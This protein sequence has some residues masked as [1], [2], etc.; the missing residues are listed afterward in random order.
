MEEK[1]YLHKLLNMFNPRISLIIGLISI[2]IFPVLVKWAAVS[3]ITSAFYR[4]FIGFVCLLPYV[5]ITK[6][7][8]VPPKSLW[9]SVIICG[10]LFG[11]D[12]AVWN[13]SIHY[14]NATQAT[15]LTNLAPIWVGIGSFFFLANKPKKQ[16]WLGTAVAISGLAVL[17]GAE[18]FSQM[19]FDKGFILALI[20]GILY[21]TYMIV[22]QTVLTHLKIVSFMTLSMGVSSIYLLIIC[23]VL[24]EP[25]WYFSNTVWG[26]MAIQGIICQLIGW[27][28]LSYAVQKMDAQRVSL[29]LLSQGVITG[30][31][32]WLFI[33]EQIS[34]RMVIGGIIILAGI[35]I[36]FR[37][38]ATN[39]VE[40]RSAT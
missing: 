20:S 25:L 32:A 21:A 18:T 11:T 34:L 26:V 13:V 35:G 30:V 37:Q 7:L 1:L 27:L 19:Q 16:F 33:D 6:Q 39:Q 31:M 22:S 14:S 2:S 24:G 4:L 29:S 28:A 23:L 8:T 9:V 40:S 36:T 15:L 17:L 5:L 38:S 12:I 3:G 10:I